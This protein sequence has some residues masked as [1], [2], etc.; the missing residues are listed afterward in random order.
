MHIHLVIT[1]LIFQKL[2]SVTALRNHLGGSMFITELHIIFVSGSMRNF[3][4]MDKRRKAY[5]SK[6]VLTFLCSFKAYI[7][8]LLIT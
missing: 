5:T 3:G 1:Y 2:S 8:V 6:A 7:K 4:K